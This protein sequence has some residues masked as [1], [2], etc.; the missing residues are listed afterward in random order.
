MWWNIDFLVYAAF[1]STLCFFKIQQRQRKKYQDYE[2]L[3]GKSN[4]LIPSTNSKKS[5]VI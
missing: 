3:N 4:N 1:L 2:F 5:Y